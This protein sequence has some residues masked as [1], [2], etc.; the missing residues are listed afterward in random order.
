MNTAHSGGSSR[1]V[2]LALV[3]N[4]GVSLAIWIGGVV[5]EIDGLRRASDEE[6]FTT[7]DGTGRLYRR[8]L[9]ILEQRVVVDV[10]AGASAGGINGIVLGAA[11]FAG[12]PV[13]NLRE[14]WIGLGDFR[15]LLRSPSEPNPPSL[16]KGDEVVLAK[17][18]AVLGELLE[19]ADG[20]R[21]Q[22]RRLYL[23]VT[24][25]DLY[26][27]V[28]TFHDSSERA[29]DELDYRRIFSFEYARPGADDMEEDMARGVAPD[30]LGVMRSV[31]DF[32]DQDA[33]CLLAGAARS[34]SSF[35]VAFEPH[36]LKLPAAA[37]VAEPASGEES[38]P[39]TDP[40]SPEWHWLIDGGVL[41]NQPFNPVLDRIGVL[42]LEGMPTKRVVA[43]V[44]PYVNEPGSLDAA[45]PEETS[46]LA[47]YGASGGLPR[48]L[49]KLQS[50]DRVSADWAEQ[51][52]AQ[53]D[54]TRLWVTLRGGQLA[55]AAE[56]LFEAYVR[57]RDRATQ[58]T[59]GQ[60]A[61]P[62]FRPGEG[63]L[64][65][66]AAID[67]R[68]LLAPPPSSTV[69]PTS[70]ATDAA[71]QPL[72]TEPWLP[73]TVHWS[74]SDGP[75]WSWG[76]AAAERAAAWALLSLRQTRAPSVEDPTGAAGLDEARAEVARLAGE[77]VWD[78][79]SEKVILREAFTALPGDDVVARARAAFASVS[80]VLTTLQGRFV[81]L[82]GA[83]AELNR[84]LPAN[85][86]LPRVRDLLHLEVVRNALSIGDPRVPCPF[87]FLFMSAGVDNSLGHEASEPNEKLAGMKLGHFAGFLKR[88]WRANDWLWGRL[89][90]VEHVLRA[91][92]DLD[93]LEELRTRTGL[94][95][96]LAQ[97]AFLVD[98]PDSEQERYAVEQAWAQSLRRDRQRHGHARPVLESA[99][100]DI[101]AE[102]QFAAAL[103]RAADANEADR[104]YRE[105]CLQCCRAALAAR[106]QLE[107][108]AEDL[109]RVAETA[110]DDGDAGA[111]KLASGLLWAGRFFRRD[112]HLRQE[113]E[114]D[115]DTTER[116]ALFKAL[117]IGAE[118]SPKDELSSRLTLDLGA[119]GAAVGAAMLAGSRSGLPASVRVALATLRGITLASSAVV[120]L[121]ARSPAVGAALIFVL[122]ALL[123]WGI[124]S[125]GVLLGSL[126]PAL[127][128]VVLI[129]GTALL[130]VATGTFEQSIS[131]TK[132]L[133]AFSALLGVPLAF[134]LTAEW[135]GAD[136]FPGWL[137]SHISAWAVTLAAA[138][139]LAAACA[140]AARGILELSLR[141][142]ADGQTARP[143]K[144]EK[145]LLAEN[146]RLR[147]ALQE[148]SAKPREHPHA[149]E[150]PHAALEPMRAIPLRWIR[151]I[152]N[153]YRALAIAAL[154]VLALGFTLDRLS[155]TCTTTSCVPTDW[156]DVA[157][158]RR[159]TILVV[160]LVLVF[161]LSAAIVELVLPRLEKHRATRRSRDLRPPGVPAQ[162]IPGPAGDFVRPPRHD[163]TEP[164]QDIEAE[165]RSP[166][167]SLDILV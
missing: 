81:A 59:F 93:R 140:A 57:T 102:A 110:A 141:A 132:R 66:D 32:R 49:S 26:G 96:E 70:A 51:R 55:E 33:A 115:L 17:L 77:L 2:R 84:R 43:Y 39:L 30:M 44:V 18:Q 161:L 122:S 48:T 16:L 83:I 105:R 63:V 60:W 90:G 154:A 134:A 13:P 99:E 14:T 146:T 8:L 89:D 116:V 98:E 10:I 100:R 138:L 150:T 160:L 46:A 64:G 127:A 7:V 119:Q 136:G 92:L 103:A 40:G 47:S 54:T 164:N 148:P 4:G 121:L 25:T 73:S 155:R 80:T 22:Q 79:R 24:A 29:F 56:A 20:T 19:G 5:S 133:L 71:E 117:A 87:E 69:D 91:T 166:V 129:G 163:R 31:V 142:H 36:R 67:P 75:A 82:D 109:E 124:V 45:P 1:E 112:A 76:F 159:G 114:R 145:D 125:P 61:D 28:R 139:A 126:T 72:P 37:R 107:I 58:R 158:E 74:A 162:G 151:T 65:Q 23:F 153:V 130:T 12:R 21:C 94:A 156:R 88:S 157:D 131:T 50:L 108:L 118:E 38:A 86:T 106:I 68:A 6:H 167:R 3:L 165:D 15:T 78:I 128:I 11:I 137:D 120:R 35:P 152:L 101:A 9:G 62:G 34:T 85:L 41:D 97:L 144:R 147:Q 113:G 149:P 53:E 135:P 95:G 52:I 104:N 143:S 123:V 27:Y 111:N 42:P